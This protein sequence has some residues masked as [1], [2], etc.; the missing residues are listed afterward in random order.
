MTDEELV[1]ANWVDAYTPPNNSSPL[2]SVAGKWF[3]TMSLAAEFT[4]ERLSQIADVVEEVALLEGIYLARRCHPE[5]CQ[6]C[7]AFGRI[8]ERE[9]AALAELRKGMKS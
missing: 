1:R 4:R 6:R 9:Q 8:I 5:G 3:S 7:L 2:V